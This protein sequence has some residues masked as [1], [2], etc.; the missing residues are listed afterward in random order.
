MYLVLIY[1]RQSIC[2]Q[3]YGSNIGVKKLYYMLEIDIWEITPYSLLLP[4]F[5]LHGP[6][7]PGL[8]FNLKLNWTLYM[9]WLLEAIG[10]RATGNSRPTINSRK[11]KHFFYKLHF[12]SVD[13]GP[14]LQKTETHWPR[15]SYNISY[16]IIIIS[17][18]SCCHS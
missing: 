13:G 1:I 4:Y 7:R 14:C 3:S 15:F 6:C 9:Q 5:L 16:S 17:L 8:N 12:L 10:A 11:L 2:I 18:Y